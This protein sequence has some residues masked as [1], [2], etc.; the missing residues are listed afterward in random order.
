MGD[1]NIKNIISNINSDFG[2]KNTDTVSSSQLKVEIFKSKK[3]DLSKGVVF[4]RT[5]VDNDAFLLVKAEMYKDF[6]AGLKQKL[7][8]GINESGTNISAK[9]R[10]LEQGIIASFVSMDIKEQDQINRV[11]KNISKKENFEFPLEL[12]KKDEKSGISGYKG[13]KYYISRMTPSGNTVPATDEQL[14]K[15]AKYM[16][17]ELDFALADALSLKTDRNMSSKDL[18]KAID[19]NLSL[20][21]QNYNESFISRYEEGYV[22][23]KREK[24]TD[25]KL[26]PDEYL[27]S[28][29]IKFNIDNCSADMLNKIKNAFLYDGLETNRPVMLPEVVVNAKKKDVEFK[30]AK[31]YSKMLLNLRD[32]NNDFIFL[33]NVKNMLNDF[34][35][36][37]IDE[38]RN[39]KDSEGNRKFKD[40][41]VDYLYLLKNINDKTKLDAFKYLLNSKDENNKERFNM[42][43]IALLLDNIS[44]VND[45]QYL[46]ILSEIKNSDGNFKYDSFEIEKLVKSKKNKNNDT[47]LSDSDENI[48]LNSFLM[49]VVDTKR[50]W[51]EANVG[52][53]KAKKNDGITICP[54][55]KEGTSLDELAE[56]TYVGDVAAIGEAVY[57]K[58]KD[59]KMVKMNLTR[60]KYLELFPPVDRFKFSQGKIGD[61]WLIST[62]DNIMNNP[63]TRIHLYEL[64]S[65]EGDDMYVKLPKSKKTVKFPSSNVI[66]SELGRNVE[67]AKGIQMIEQAFAV[68]RAAQR[69]ELAAN[70]ESENENNVNDDCCDITKIKDI[71]ALM[72]SLKSGTHKEAMENLLPINDKMFIDRE[73]GYNLNKKLDMKKKLEYMIKQHGRYNLLMFFATKNVNSLNVESGLREEYDLYS[74]HGYSIKDYDANDGTITFSNPWQSESVTCINIYDLMEQIAQITFLVMK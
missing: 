45:F 65:Q 47:L 37:A 4:E 16:G 57:C 34:N 41:Q 61:C 26:Y 73:T 56:N 68:H 1:F 64:F 21:K 30:N 5:A 22:V 50:A 54:T 18:H 72:Y 3:K 58:T 40:E 17:K 32:S 59:D 36:Q 63:E 24:F 60:T 7:Y 55:Y 12:T 15:I 70:Y 8:N 23:K 14:V 19:D 51:I 53:D 11:L 9:R 20:L 29:K 43:S 62:I 25:D 44:T 35:T 48:P 31:E 71:D 6:I 66:I 2:P 10:N 13:S 38:V 27:N 69:H 28:Q 74:N 42:T 46:K 49:K 39:L 52:V 67:G 33:I